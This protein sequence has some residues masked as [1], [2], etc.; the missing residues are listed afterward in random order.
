[1]LT[2]DEARQLDGLSVGDLVAMSATHPG[3]RQARARTAG[4]EFHDFRHYQPGDDP[5]FVDWTIYSRLRQLM[6]HV[7]PRDARQ[8]VHILLDT[9]RS[10]IAGTPDKR[11]CAVKIAA[12]LAY[13]ALQHRDSVG[14]TTFDARVNLSLAPGAG[15]G[16]LH[17]VLA[18]LGSTVASGQSDPNRAL[19]DFGAVARGPGLA[20]VISDF[21]HD[22]GGPFEGL[23]CLLHRG[24]LPVVVQVV[25]PE[26]LDPQCREQIELVDLEDPHA[27]PV[28]VDARVVAGYRE[29]MAAHWNELSEFCREHGM[30][31]VRL[32]SSFGFARIVDA[33]MRAGF[34]AG[35]SDSQ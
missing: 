11:A 25:A 27:P 23:Q 13:V 1:M 9:S 33:F 28:L 32:E 22:R 8:Q 5:R 3:R 6:V 35:R 15:R 14:L 26:E 24:L 31:A 29:R 10:M 16:Q 4:L 19:S 18:A 21:F 7:S 17:R 12:M 34:L 20:V 30:P 2:A